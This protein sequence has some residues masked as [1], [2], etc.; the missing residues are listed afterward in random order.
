[1]QVIEESILITGLK[2]VKEIGTTSGKVFEILPFDQIYG[3]TQAT[4]EYSFICAVNSS[5]Y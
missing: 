5:Q 1:V 3:P 2:S 4:L